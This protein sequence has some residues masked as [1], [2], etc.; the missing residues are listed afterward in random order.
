MLHL[1]TVEP[2]TFSVLKKLMSLPALQNFALVGG[3]ALSLKYGHRTSID[4][5]LFWNGNFT[6]DSI[7]NALE[8]YFGSDFNYKKS[9]DAFGI[10]CFIKNVKVDIVNF[11]HPLLQA[12]EN[13]DGIRMYSN[14]DIAAMKIQAFLGRGKK[15]DFWDLH[16]LLKHYTLQEIMS[17]HKEKYPSQMLAIGIPHAITYFVDADESEE[18]LSLQG[19]TWENIKK[20][21][22]KTVRD[23]LS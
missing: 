17:W 19:Q 21:I 18:P 11:P 22:S 10:F 23:F 6:N 3:T 4:L 5:D 8:K 7:V 20:D 9:N 14:A 2:G 13:I 12:V 16:T 15:K 1:E